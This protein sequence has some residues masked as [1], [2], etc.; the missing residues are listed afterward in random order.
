MTDYGITDDEARA[1]LADQGRRV[2][3]LWRALDLDGDDVLSA[4]EIER[5]SSSLLALDSNGDGSLTV[6]ELGGPFRWKDGPRG[7]AIMRILDLDGD[8]VITADDIAAAPERLRL[9]DRG[10]RGH[11][12]PE[13]DIPPPNPTRQPR[14]GGPA[15]FLSLQDILRSY[16]DDDTGT[17]MPGADHRQDDSYLLIY[18]HSNARD[19][20]YANSLFLMAPDGARV[21]RW[22]TYL[23]ASETV[24]PYL[25]DDGLLI[26][27]SCPGNWL[28]TSSFPVGAHGVISMIEPD[29]TVVWEYRL[30]EPLER[31]LHHDFEP[32]PNGNILVTMFRG[33]TYDEAYAMGW[34]DQPKDS[35]LRPPELQRLWTETILEL[36]PDLTTGGTEVVWEW[37]SSDHLVQDIYPDRPNYGEIGPGCRKIDLNYAQYE[38]F[39]F[40][41]GQIMHV[42]TISYNAEHDQIML[43]SAMHEELWVIDH[44]TTTEEAEGERGDLL[45][46]WGNPSSHGA[47][48]ET[49]K[50][51][52]WQH[53]IHWIPDD[54]PHR[55]DVLIFNN[56]PRRSMDGTPN[57][58]ELRMSFG[59]GYSDI[60]ELTL[61]LD[62]D[63]NWTWNTDDPMNGAEL[64]WSYNGDGRGDWYSAF[65]SGARRLRNGNTVMG[66][67]Y[68]KRLRQVTPDGD[69]VLD[70]R[71]GGPGRFF[72]V[73]PIAADHPGL[74]ALNLGE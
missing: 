11:L 64:V 30:I 4:E 37:H 16:H 3:T 65:M 26:R 51:L 67:G 53:D 52:Y 6:D 66:Q 31:V 17:V 55:G 56:G 23:H 12:L 14:F 13:D 38:A 57:N 25:R 18:E 44:A 15:G 32:M 40:S 2:R 71:P 8:G 5:A 21:H 42:N 41:M 62:D 43:S 28:T 50:T 19:A 69:I 63:G 34:R 1:I 72:R 9:L 58:A 36:K 22:P 59:T 73:V 54:V 46:R 24:S 35:L 47:G 20:Q 61:P 48:P 29:G 45:Y 49:D 33:F 7:S 68:D 70:F 60:L 27:T 74:T 10:G 39:W